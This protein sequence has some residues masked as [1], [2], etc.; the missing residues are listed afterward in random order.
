MGAPKGNQNSKGHK[1]SGG[2]PSAYKERVNAETLANMY[3]EKQD[4]E[5][6][7]DDIRAGKFSIQQRHILN[8]MEGEQKAIDVI[9]RK[10]FPDTMKV[11]E[12][13]TIK[14]DLYEK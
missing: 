10:L 2:R 1:G 12:D 3:F 6:I 14:V 8:A 13:I 5:K 7:E 9:V 4:Q 11:E